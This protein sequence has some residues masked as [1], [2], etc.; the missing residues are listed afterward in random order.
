[1]NNAEWFWHNR[2]GNLVPLLHCWYIAFTAS[3]QLAL[4]CDE[5]NLFNLLLVSTKSVTL[6]QGSAI[7]KIYL[8]A[9]KTEA[10]FTRR[11]YYINI[12]K[13]VQLEMK[14]STRSVEISWWYSKKKS[15]RR[16]L[17]IHVYEGVWRCAEK[18]HYDGIKI[19]FVPSLKSF[20]VSTIFI[21]DCA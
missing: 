10:K 9:W 3:W 14:A 6:E 7:L 8:T 15:M 4:Q 13:C 1:M 2:V 17:H 12:L 5:L 18:S 11:K 16:K 20:H 21:T 19:C